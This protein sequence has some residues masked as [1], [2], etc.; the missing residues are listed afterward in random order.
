MTSAHSLQLADYD[1]PGTPD[2]VVTTKPE[3]GARI[4]APARK[5]GIE[6]AV[7]WSLWIEAREAAVILDK[8]PDHFMKKVRRDLANRGMAMRCKGPDGQGQL[9]WFIK[10]EYSLKL[11]GGAVGSAQ[12]LPEQWYK[13]TDKQRNQ[14]LSRASCVKRYRAMLTDTKTGPVGGWITGLIATLKIDHKNISISRRSIARWHKLYNCEA[15]LM[16]LVDRRGGS[17]SSEIDPAAYQFF[18]DLY[19]TTSAMDATYCHKLTVEKAEAECWRWFSRGR[20]G[21]LQAKRRLYNEVPF[22]ARIK[23]RDPE[24][25]RNTMSPHM[26]MDPEAFAA[27][28]RW[29][30]DHCVLDLFCLFPG[31]GGGRVGRPWLTAW[32][33]TK[34][35]K[36]VGWQLCESPSSES[37]R[38]AFA[39]GMRDPSNMGGPAI[40]HIDNGKDYKC[41]AFVGNRF[42]KQKKLLKKGYADTP[43]FHGLYGML[44]IDVIFAIPK[45]SRGK[46]A[47]ESWFGYSLHK[48][49][50]KLWTD[51]YAGKDHDH[52]PPGL[53]KRLKDKRSLPTFEDIRQSVAL[54]I[55]AYN[56]D[57]EHGK[58]D[59]MQRSPNAVML[60]AQERVF[61]DPGVLDFMELTYSAPRRVT[62][63]A[64]SIHAL[65]QTL[66]YTSTSSA[67]LA[68]SNTGRMVRVGYRQEDLLGQVYIFSD[69]MQ[70]MLCTANNERAGTSIKTEAGRADAKSAIAIQ[71]KVDKAHD[72]IRK[73]G[74]KAILP[75]ETLMLME[76]AK[77]KQAEAE[78][79][80]D[81]DPSNAGKRLVQTPL[82]GQSNKLRA[83]RLKKAVGAETASGSPGISLGDITQRLAAKAGR[84]ITTSEEDD[85]EVTPRMTGLSISER[86]E[87]KGKH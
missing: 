34:S 43:E 28:E 67:F 30:G 2:Q 62:R 3:G 55:D 13:L 35:R 46:G 79:A 48:H 58:E 45:N 59:I 36:I 15:D 60:E 37:I 50:D 8:N 73:H 31:S 69:D 83:A 14:A 24:R 78:Q 42:T 5:A 54:H 17:A 71:R 9:R 56:A 25:Y 61:A 85:V 57:C 41:E 82:D 26:V 33:D 32:M 74:G 18:K 70:Q 10:R 16:K 40:V 47:V 86:L 76:A 38:A 12:R 23:A 22:I 51:V 68:L 29:Q 4:E 72:T 53:M 19:L 65:G 84:V 27:G 52:R 64:V 6:N 20:K 66:R 44:G 75:K 1:A 49:H 7:D 11:D 80:P 39:K 81:P 77:R 87:R 63:Q 21:Y